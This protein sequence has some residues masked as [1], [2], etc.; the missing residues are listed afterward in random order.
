[1]MLGLFAPAASVP[2]P[3]ARKEIFCYSCEA[4]ADGARFGALVV[5]P[6]SS[7]HGRNL[8]QDPQDKHGGKWD[9]LHW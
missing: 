7:E 9:F 5:I 4:S 2:R 3:W 8:P 6:W 1:V